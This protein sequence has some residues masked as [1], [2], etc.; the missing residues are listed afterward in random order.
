M[1]T[2][3]ISCPTLQKELQAAL[4]EVG[5]EIEVIYMAERLHSFPQEMHS[6]LQEQLD[7]LQGYDRII[8]LISGCGGATLGLRSPH[9]E[10]VLPKTR[11]CLDILLAGATLAD[12]NRPQHG[13]F[14]TESWMKF[15]QQST[16]DLEKLTQ[17]RGRAV[18]EATLKKIYQGFEHFYIID[19]G[20]YDIEPVREYI[21]PLVNLLGGTLEVIPGKFNVLKKLAVGKF[22]EDFWVIPQGGSV[23]LDAYK[24]P[25][26]L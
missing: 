25:E 22:D 16:L 18:A 23:P 24:K 1:K 10:L 4:A 17:E 15:M 2:V 13:I 21:T 8:I 5:A 26:V 12:I 19:T 11:D 14:L 3:I 7:N 20:A 6:Q 9:A